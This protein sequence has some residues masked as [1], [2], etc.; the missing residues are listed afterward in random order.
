MVQL[1]THFCDAHVVRPV[2]QLTA[3]ASVE[4]MPGEKK[5]VTFRIETSQLGYYN[6][7]MDF[8]VEP[9]KLEIMIGTS[10]H[11]IAFSD[12]LMLTGER[13]NVMGKRSF[14]SETQINKCK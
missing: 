12:S 7:D 10:A 11:D 3:F 14:C 6:E 2:K 5:E 4:L 13:V 9:G 1:Y 8:V